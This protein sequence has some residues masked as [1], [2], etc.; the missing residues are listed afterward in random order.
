M[1]T[2]IAE[3]DIKRISKASSS[4]SVRISK[5]KIKFS[6]EIDTFISKNCKKRYLAILKLAENEK[7]TP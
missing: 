7:I 3:L 6:E 1:Q 4:R 5:N 2:A